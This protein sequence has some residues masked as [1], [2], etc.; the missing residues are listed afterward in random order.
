M[1]VVVQINFLLIQIS[2][3]IDFLLITDKKISKSSAFP[4]AQLAVLLI[5]ASFH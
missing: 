1:V 4:I 5:V 3:S 2:D